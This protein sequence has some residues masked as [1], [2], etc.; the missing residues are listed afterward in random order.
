[1]WC[2]QAWIPFSKKWTWTEPLNVLSQVK[3]PK[4]CV[5]VGA[6]T[7]GTAPFHVDKRAALLTGPVPHR[8]DALLV[9]RT[10]NLPTTSGPPLPPG[11]PCHSANGKA[12]TGAVS[13]KNPLLFT[14]VGALSGTGEHRYQSGMKTQTLDN[15]L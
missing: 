3:T 15:Q 1:M 6:R 12:H 11:S 13:A 7:T 8:H 5:L 10:L 2:V 9:R 14:V 4:L